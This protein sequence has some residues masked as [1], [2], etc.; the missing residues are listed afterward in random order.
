MRKHV[1]ISICIVLIISIGAAF[2]AFTR[3]LDRNMSALGI[4]QPGIENGPRVSSAQ[5]TNGNRLHINAP[6]RDEAYISERLRRIEYSNSF[7]YLLTHSPLYDT[8][9]DT[10]TAVTAAPQTVRLLARGENGWMYIETPSGAKWFDPDWDSGSAKLDVPVFGQRALGLPTGC[11]IVSLSML[12]NYF[13]E[14]DPIQLVNEMPRST[15]PLEGFRGD[16]FTTNGFTVLPPALMELTESYMGSAKDMTGA[17]IDEIKAQIA[18]GRPVVVWVRGLLNFNVHALCVNGYDENGIYYN[19]PWRAS[20]DFM[21]Y[22]RFLGYWD[23]PVRDTILNRVYP[24]R[25]ALS[26]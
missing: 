18:I 10:S 16:P 25:M 13:F 20:N 12:M 17:C 19:D 14:I 26:F 7:F 8:I 9:G 22:E 2:Y 24:P 6:T 11:E 3:V 21:T 1:F 15:D 4:N 5:G 23:D